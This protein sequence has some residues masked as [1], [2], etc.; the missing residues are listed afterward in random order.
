[1]D[2]PYCGSPHSGTEY[3]NDFGFSCS[4]NLLRQSEDTHVDDLFGAAPQNGAAWLYALFPR[5]YIDVNRTAEDIDPKLLSEP[6]PVEQFGT[7]T[8]TERSLDGIGLISRL[9]KGQ[10]IYDRALTAEEIDAR[11]K[12]YFI[13]YL[14]ALQTF[15]DEALDTFGTVFHINAHSMPHNSAF[16]QGVRKPV[17]FCL[18]TLDGTSSSKEFVDVVRRCLQRQGYHVTTNK[19]YRGVEIV[20]RFG[21]PMQDK[22][23]LQIEVNRSLYMDEDTRRK[24]HGFEKLKADIDALLEDASDYVRGQAKPIP[25]AAD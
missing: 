11:R 2:P 1:M 8:P 9:V 15:H 5:T 17:D 13:P 23:A 18:G 12:N 21:D 16:V 19:P 4:K 14:D 3:P 20:R 25:M 7:I 24:N 22:H 6:W 10:K